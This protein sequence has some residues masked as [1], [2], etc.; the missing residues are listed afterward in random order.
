MS[1]PHSFDERAS[2]WDDDE[3]TARARSVSATIVAAVRPTAATR[4]LEYGAGTGLA[5]QF[6]A[7]SVGSVTLADPSAGM[8]RV[9]TEKVASGV[10]PQGTRIWDLNL[11]SAEAPDEQFDLIIMVL[12]LHHVDNVALV[13][14]RLG[15]MLADGA[16]LCIVDLE[17]ED[18][19]FHGD[20]AGVSHG[21]DEATLDPALDAAGLTAEYHHGIYELDKDGRPYPLFLAVCTLVEPNRARHLKQI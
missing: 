10:L 6:L 17:A 1:H 4:L 2:T 14:T 18:G 11:D 13:L 3:K 20:S 12:A 21:F 15:T 9:A 16:A 19:S 5:A 7:P 8:R